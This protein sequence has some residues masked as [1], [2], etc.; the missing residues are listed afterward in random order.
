MS[1]LRNVGR[2]DLEGERSQRRFVAPVRG[3]N[4]PLVHFGRED[5]YDA[6]LMWLGPLCET[7][8][9]AEPGRV[10]PEMFRVNC[11]RCVKGAEL[12]FEMGRLNFSHG[13]AR[14]GPNEVVRLDILREQVRRYFP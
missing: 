10:S 11:A 6:G 12:L 13:Y 3:P 5:E 4:D 8:A 14:G 2:G 9:Y 1:E 7:A